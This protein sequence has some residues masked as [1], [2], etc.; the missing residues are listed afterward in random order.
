MLL[1][2]RILDFFRP[3]PKKINDIKDDVV[4]QIA[5]AGPL[6][7]KKFNIFDD[8]DGITPE[9]L[10]NHIP[11]QELKPLNDKAFTVLSAKTINSMQRKNLSPHV[12][13]NPMQSLDYRIYETLLKTTFI[14]S[15]LDSFVQYVV[16]QGF[17]PE[18]ELVNPDSNDETNTKLIE[19]HQDIITKLLEI[20][21]SIETFSD[22]TLDISFQQ[23]F[24]AMIMSTLGY[25]RSA[26]IFS[27]DKS[28]VIDGK[29]YEEIPSHL[30]F[31]PAQDLG[32]IDIDQQTRRLKS[33]QWK[34]QYSTPIPVKDMVYM[35]N[36]I[37]SSKAHNSYFYGISLLS[38]LISASKMI[39]TLLSETFPA[40]AKTTW[41]GVFSL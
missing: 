24:T 14:G 7:G 32:I 38:P 3:L 1:I 18:L 12:F 19:K 17:K 25:N 35:W 28:V 30:I 8:F 20:D 21:H 9:Q 5:I 10:A 22:G 40:M 11:S 41:A 2:K 33:V 31:A 15:L 36:P 13:A 23:K 29:T 26:L 39:R 6:G 27:Y 37:T 16:G 4:D 34:H